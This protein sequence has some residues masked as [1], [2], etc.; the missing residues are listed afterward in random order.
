MAPDGGPQVALVRD[1]GRRQ[2]QYKTL[3]LLRQLG[4]LSARVEAVVYEVR[5][6]SLHNSMHT[7][8]QES[9]CTPAS[10]CTP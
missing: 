8:A 7:T 1:R 2:K 4:E 10:P 6:T 3:E 5:L 9:A